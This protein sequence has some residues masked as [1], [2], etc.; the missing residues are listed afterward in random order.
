M[1]IRRL[2]AFSASL[3]LL[4][5]AAVLTPSDPARAGCS[6]GDLLNAVVNTVTTVATGSCSTACDNS[7]TCGIAVWLTAALAGVAT[8]DS[9]AAVDQFC[10]A[11]K[12]VITPV[13]TGASDA[14]S[15]IKGLQK[16]DP[17]LAQDVLS[18]LS[19]V[20]SDVSDPV[21]AALCGCAA[22]QSLSQLGAAFGACLED[23]LC[24]G[25]AALGHPCT[26]T[27]P[28]PVLANCAQSN[29]NCNYNNG[30]AACQGGTAAFPTLIAGQNG[31]PIPPY[32]PVTQ[33]QNS[34][35]TLVTGGGSGSDN[36]GHCAPTYYCFCP[37]PM[38]GKWVS[39]QAFNDS[40]G[41]PVGNNGQPTSG[42]FIFACE[43]PSGTHADPSGATTGG[44]SVC[45]CDN[46]SL[47]ANFATDAFGGM[48]PPPNC[49][50][51]QVRHN[52]NGNCVTPCSNP[53]EGMTFDGACCNPA[54]V[55]SCGTC[56]PPGTTPDPAT[57]TCIP[58]Q[59]IQ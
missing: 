26:C 51:G 17:S 54:Q 47:P 34:T 4:T 59:T 32:T 44:V 21:S 35:G 18:E 50:A 12:N 6:A 8:D 7:A 37:A 15:V 48:C 46:S 11:M 56:C 40:N 23:F 42:W 10:T 24:A 49:A 1:S 16:V 27:A 53:S 30:D 55:T 41:I 20:L 45:L 3:G 36:N 58:P 2:I 19:S 9:Q 33:T 38:Q 28:P 22:E 13:K 14:Q 31:T 52:G 25:D 29:A 57:G 39:D 5:A 43:C